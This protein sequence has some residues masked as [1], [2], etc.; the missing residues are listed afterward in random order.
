MAAA[1]ALPQCLRVFDSGDDVLDAGCDPAVC[2][3]VVVVAYAAGVVASRGADRSD[4]AVSA[5]AE[6]YTAIE[7]MHDGVAGHDD[8]V[9]VGCPALAGDEHRRRCEQMMIWVLTRGR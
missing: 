3:V 4:A 9:A 5:V 6:D 2:L 1:A 7:H 8:V